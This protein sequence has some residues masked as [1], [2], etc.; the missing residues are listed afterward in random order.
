MYFEDDDDTIKIDRDFFSEMNQT[1]FDKSDK[2]NQKY[3]TI[4]SRTVKMINSDSDKVRLIEDE[5]DCLSDSI[6]IQQDEDE[7]IHN[8]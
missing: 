6:I 3:N 5:Q 4:N 8:V 7:I 2:F 1:L